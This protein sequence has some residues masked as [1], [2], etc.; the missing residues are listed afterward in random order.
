MGNQRKLTLDTIATKDRLTGEDVLVSVLGFVLRSLT[1]L[2]AVE[3]FALLL[4]QR[5]ELLPEAGLASS[6]AAWSTLLL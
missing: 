3:M 1:L 4:L 6:E 5:L 2:P